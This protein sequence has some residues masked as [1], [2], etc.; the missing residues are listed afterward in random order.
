MKSGGWRGQAEGRGLQPLHSRG[1]DTVTVVVRGGYIVQPGQVS[2]GA[3]VYGGAGW[4]TQEGCSSPGAP[5]LGRDPVPGGPG[6]QLTEVLQLQQI[7]HLQ[8]LF[9]M[10]GAGAGGGAEG[11]PGPKYRNAAV[12][13]QKEAVKMTV[14]AKT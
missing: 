5:R 11:W 4:G 7:F 10:T 12:E 9:H 14:A 2:P 8:E 6:L 13:M 3:G 1:L